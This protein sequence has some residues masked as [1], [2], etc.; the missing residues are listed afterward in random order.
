MYTQS[1]S[2]VTSYIGHMHSCHL[3]QGILH[4]EEHSTVRVK[5]HEMYEIKKYIGYVLIGRNVGVN[6]KII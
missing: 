4:N 3:E 2:V 1:L 6:G 5:K